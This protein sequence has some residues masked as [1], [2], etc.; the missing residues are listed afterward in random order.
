MTG[1]GT[2]APDDLVGAEEAAALLEVAA[3]R[4]EVMVAEGML[5]PV[6]DGELR[7]SRA[8]VVAARELGG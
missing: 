5:T 2:G 3:D 6:G 1:S 4:I 7:F 8:E